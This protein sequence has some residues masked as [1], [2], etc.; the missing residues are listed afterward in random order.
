MLF[1]DLKS[2]THVCVYFMFGFSHMIYL[3]FFIAYLTREIGMQVFPA[4]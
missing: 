1:Q 2:F 3:T 4:R